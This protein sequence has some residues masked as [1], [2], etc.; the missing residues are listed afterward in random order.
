MDE[1]GILEARAIVIAAEEIQSVRA[2]RKM[3][4]CESEAI[5]E[6]NSDPWYWKSEQDEYSDRF[7]QWADRVRSMGHD[8]DEYLRAAGLLDEDKGQ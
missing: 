2:Y 5:M 7:D 1:A 8:P 6:H 4:H 3:G